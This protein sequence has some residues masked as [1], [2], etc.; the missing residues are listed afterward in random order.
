MKLEPEVQRLKC[1]V[2]K[3]IDALLKKDEEIDLLKNHMKSLETENLRLKEEQRSASEQIEVK[4][5]SAVSESMNQELYNFFSDFCELV[6]KI[7]K[8]GKFIPYKNV[9]KYS[10]S[11]CKVE[12]NTFEAYVK[13]VAGDAPDFINKCADFLCIKSE[14]GKCVFNNDKLRIYFLN[15]KLVN[16]VLGDAANAASGNCEQDEKKVV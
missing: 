1:K 16:A 10:N 7:Y 9:T 3:Q 6:R 4:V 13:E 11:F 5:D 2:N 15:R 14:A 8:N 12:R